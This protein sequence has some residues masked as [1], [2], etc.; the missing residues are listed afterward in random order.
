MRRTPRVF[1]RG[2]PYAIAAL[3]VVLVFPFRPSII[4]GGI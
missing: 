4:S 2:K 3:L 1:E